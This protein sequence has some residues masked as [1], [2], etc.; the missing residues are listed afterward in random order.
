[1]STLTTFESGKERLE[2]MLLTIKKGRTQLPEFQRDFLWDDEHVRSLLASVS[3]SYPI[4]AVMMLQAGNPEANFKKRLIEG[5]AL[6]EMPEPETLVLD[7]QQRLTS[8]FQ[9]LLSQ[10]AVVT[11]DARGN[12]ILRWYY[13]DMIKAL[14]PN[15]DRVDAVIG[16]P[17][18]RRITSFRGEIL[19]DYST[20]E[21]EYQAR[22][23]PVSQV[24]E[25]A[26]WRRGYGKYY[27]GESDRLDEFDAFESQ[28][29]D[30]FKQ[31]SVPVIKLLKDT[32]LDAVCQVFEKVNTGGVPLNV[33]ELLTAQY[34]ILDFPLRDDWDARRKRLKTGVLANIASTDFLQAV[35]LLATRDRRQRALDS[36]VPE[37]KAPGVSCK[38]KDILHLKL[39]EYRRWADPVTEGFERAA[40]LLMTQKIFDAR[41]LPYQTQL[42]P[43]AAMCAVLGPRVETVGLQNKLVKWYWCGVFGELYGSAT[44]SRLALDLPQVLSWIDGGPVPNT[45]EDSHFAPQRLL[46]LRTRNSAAY[47]GLSA[48]LMRDGCEDFRT[49]ESIGVQ[50]YFADKIDIHHI[51]PQAWCNQH[52][53]GPKRCDSVI[54]KTPLSYKTNRQIGGSAPSTYLTRMQGDADV[55]ESRM[56]DILASHRIDASALRFDDFDSFFRKRESELL[57]LIEVAM[58]KPIARDSVEITAPEPT[59]Y[60]LDVQPDAEYLPEEVA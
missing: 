47:K 4:G 46:S 44:E 50:M 13:F 1:M 20:P 60:E 35:T 7:G 40:R 19:A 36:N 27:H 26:A 2:E 25:G 49:G 42:T 34:A 57:R 18:N 53:I 11:K 23:Y 41:D 10:R 22:M 45:I 48:L 28:I 43:L 29:I 59:E 38:R 15:T 16:V 37:D 17:E 24:F 54:N 21:A 9:T 8:L 51:F 55:E 39:D 6:D 30:V 3:L 32:P 56:N 12:R 52:K 33:F 58:D 31:Y 14:D 5:V